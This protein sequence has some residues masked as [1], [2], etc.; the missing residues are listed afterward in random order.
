ME[1]IFERINGRSLVH[2]LNAVEE[3]VVDREEPLYFTHSE[4]E[5]RVLFHSHLKPLQIDLSRCALQ[6]LPLGRVYK[7][8]RTF[9]PS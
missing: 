5:D 2:C 8:R 1:D 7:G 9:S 6:S 4:G 3:L